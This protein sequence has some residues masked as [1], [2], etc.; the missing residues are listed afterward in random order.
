MLFRS[1][2]FRKVE[3]EIMFGKGISAS[4]SLIDAAVKYDIIDKKGAWYAFGEEKIGQGRENAR[5]FIE[6]NPEIAMKIEKRVRELM[7][8]T[9]P[10]PV[11]I[12]PEPKPV[13][14]PAPVAVRPASMTTGAATKTPSTLAGSEV[15]P[16]SKAPGKQIQP[17][18]DDGLF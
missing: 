18:A 3:L 1:P 6:Q 2:P 13:V 16:A 17:P 11:P 5:S 10:Q 15:K 7:F 8:N 14:N 9:D 4:G 12:P